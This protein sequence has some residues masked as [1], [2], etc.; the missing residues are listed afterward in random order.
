M[1]AEVPLFNT[2]SRSFELI[3]TN[4]E[5]RALT[6]RM[7]RAQ[8]IAIY[9]TDA[10]ATTLWLALLLLLP[11]PLPLLLLLLLLLLAVGLVCNLLPCCWLL[12]AG[13]VCNYVLGL[14]IGSATCILARTAATASFKLLE[15]CTLQ[16]M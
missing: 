2:R 10:L 3:M 11:L 16:I 14:Q 13:S 15:C 7:M 6:Q 12:A 9:G 4:E 5:E 1:R 8:P